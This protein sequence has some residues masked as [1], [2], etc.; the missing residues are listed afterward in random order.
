MLHPI[1]V[2]ALGIFFL[3]WVVQTVSPIIFLEVRYR[4]YTA[5]SRTFHTTNLRNLLLPHF[6]IGIADATRENKE[7]T[8]V[9]PAIF[10]E[11]P[12]V[13]NVNPTNAEEY[14]GVL[15]RAI[16]HAAGTGVPGSGKLGY[17]FAHSASPTLAKQY[18]AVFYLLG[19][20]KFDDSIY[21]WH[22]GSRFEYHVIR[23]VTTDASDMSF[24]A[25]P[26]AKETIVLQT[27]WPPATT[28]RR[29]LVFA[30]KV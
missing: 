5:L 29:L 13:F 25:A 30:E 6:H 16:A 24:L 19:K 18:N 28:L 15:K 11:E 21:L 3:L 1:A 8:L 10:V 23:S 4:Y 14:N 27:C 20:L 26:Y 17:Y 12:I 9:I 7:N 22:E 2:A